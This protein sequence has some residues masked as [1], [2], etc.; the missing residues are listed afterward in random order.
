MK[1]TGQVTYVPYCLSFPSIL[2]FRP[3][4]KF[5]LFLSNLWICSIFFGSY[6]VGA[7]SGSDSFTPSSPVAIW[8]LSSQL[9]PLFSCPQPGL[10]SWRPDLSFLFLFSNLSLTPKYWIRSFHWA[11]FKDCFRQDAPSFFS[12]SFLES[13]SPPRFRFPGLR[14]GFH[15]W[16]AFYAILEIY[17]TYLRE[18]K[19]G[20]LHVHWHVAL[21]QFLVYLREIWD[22]FLSL[23]D[24]SL[25]VSSGFIGRVQCNIT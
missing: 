20:T 6:R 12:L 10:C 18:F 9:S 23:S 16:D 25:P 2:C 15:V 19:K 24:L 11:L 3:P 14:S 7:G 4:Y 5:I 1:D 8:L 13:F 21:F 17:S 22:L